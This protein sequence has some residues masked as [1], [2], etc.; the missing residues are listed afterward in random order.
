MEKLPCNSCRQHTNHKEVRSYSQTY[1]PEDDPDMPV[2]YAE[3]TWQIVQCAGCERVS[4]RELWLTS[5]HWATNEDPTEHRYPE[6][7][8]DQV[9]VKSFRQAPDNINRIYKESIRSFNIGNY[10]LCAAGLRAVIEGICEEKIAKNE[11]MKTKKLYTLEKKINSLQK[12]KILSKEHAEILHALRFIGNEAV[13][14]LTAPPGEELKAAIEIVE[15]TLENLYG[16][17]A[18][19]WLLR[20]KQRN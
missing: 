12:K 19:G 6:V 20:N 7:D 14:E 1:T 17:S 9:P 18:K 16:L 11:Q 3:G 2:D 4:F 13:H 10:I 15:H 8:K 5:E